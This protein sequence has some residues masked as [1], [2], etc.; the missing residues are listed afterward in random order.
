V[1]DVVSVEIVV[2]FIGAVT[3]PSSAPMSQGEVLV[4]P[5]MS[6]AKARFASALK[7]VP[8]SRAEVSE[9]ERWKSS[10]PKVV[11]TKETVW[12]ALSLAPPVSIYRAGN[13]VIRSAVKSSSISFGCW[14]VNN[15][16]F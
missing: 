6:V 10:E 3:P 1:F 15:I 2:G 9:E 8:A 11:E 4:S 12:L 5:S 14:I 7:S 13:V 16:I